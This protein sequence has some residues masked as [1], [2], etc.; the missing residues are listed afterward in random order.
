MNLL[1]NSFKFTTSGYVM[2][3]VQFKKH[4]LHV[5]VVD[6]GSGIPKSFLPQ[7]F[8]PYKQVQARG[9]ERGTGL[10][11]SITKQLIQQTQGSIA[12]DSK[13]Q[14]DHGV[15]AASSGSAF[16][17][18]LPVAASKHSLDPPPLKLVKPMRIEIVH[19]G[20]H[21]DIEGLTTAWMSFGVE[22]LHTKVTTDISSDPDTIIWADLNFLRKHPDFYLNAIGKQRQL[23]LVPYNNKTLLD[24]I[25]GRTPPS[26]ILPIRKPL[27]WHRIV[28]A[29]IDTQQLL[30]SPDIDNS[31]KHAIKNDIVPKLGKESK[32]QAI[33][34]KRKTVLLVEDNKVC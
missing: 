5:K 32:K 33:L 6:T 10:G 26:H 7:L 14:H 17:L 13:Y 15:G 22:V 11:L 12:V 34:A 27:I 4:E 3:L 25:I 23:F 24:E 2:L 9:A 29:I 1:S 16:T 31:T 30:R 20:N 8:E 28:Q 18:I 21:R 19:A